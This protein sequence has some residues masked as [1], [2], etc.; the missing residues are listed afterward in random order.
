MASIGASATLGGIVASMADQDL[1]VLVIPGMIANGLAPEVGMNA[2]KS[3]E[4][5]S[6]SV[7]EHTTHQKTIR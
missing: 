6:A 1:F 3:G 2:H 5:T 4:R 7:T